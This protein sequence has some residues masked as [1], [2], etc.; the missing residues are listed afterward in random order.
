MGSKKIDLG[1][2]FANEV[3]V[4]KAKYY[5]TI[6]VRKRLAGDVGKNVTVTV[7]ARVKGIR[8]RRDGNKITTET[9]LE[10]LSM[11]PPGRSGS[12]YASMRKKTSR[13]GG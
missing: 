8:E 3:D 5:P 1:Q 10:V 4:S 9:E 2:T 13:A 6:T 12:D 11:T 7:T